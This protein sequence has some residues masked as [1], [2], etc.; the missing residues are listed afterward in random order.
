MF[1]NLVNE[2]KLSFR[3][4]TEG[5][6]LIQSGGESGLDPTLPDT[7]FIRSVHFG[8]PTVLIPGS[9]LKGVFRA[10]AEKIISS[11]GIP[12]DDLFANQSRLEKKYERMNGTERYRRSD[13]VVRLF[14][15]TYLG[16]RIFFADAF[17]VPEAPLHLGQRHHVAI[18]RITGSAQGGHLFEPEVV[19]EGTFGADVTLVNY[20]LWQLQLLA[21]ILADINEGYV[22]LGGGTSRGYGRVSIHGVEWRLRDYRPEDPAGTL[23]GYDAPDR[24]DYPPL[25]YRRRS[26]FWRGRLE[27]LD[28]FLGED[29]P[30]ADYDFAFQLAEGARERE[31]LL[32]L[33]R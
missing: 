27:G 30:F 25:Q 17:P 3:I 16:S 23:R 33:E 8:E 21:Y 13:P 4:H 14:G 31:E 28:V 15:Q 9:S 20:E 10:R 7:Q 11:M 1:K 2:L 32:S 18:N 22:P 29:G 19:E 5:P 24:L 26:Y 12:I 6:L